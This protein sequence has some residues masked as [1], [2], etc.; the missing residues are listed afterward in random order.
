MASV[1]ADDSTDSAASVEW[2]EF[3]AANISYSATRMNR[4]HRT[5][6]IAMFIAAASHGTVFAIC[7][8]AG[9][10][11]RPPTVAVQGCTGTGEYA[12]ESG[13]GIASLSPLQ[14]PTI[15]DFK[16][17]AM[18]ELLNSHL[19]T[20]S[21]LDLKSTSK[22]PA[23]LLQFE[24]VVIGLPGSTS[25][26]TPVFSHHLPIALSTVGTAETTVGIAAKDD[27]SQSSTST[28]TGGGLVGAFGQPSPLSGNKPPKYPADARRAN[29]Q[30]TVWILIDVLENG[31]V[32]S[33]T[34][35][36]SCGHAMLDQIAL[37]AVKKWKYNPAIR[38]NL[39]IR[40]QGFQRIDFALD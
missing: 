30:G 19:P 13:N 35:D 18:P 36:E 33:A 7:W 27:S 5:A 25:N 37:E 17:P 12:D 21:L 9:L 20:S 40:S 34:I 29:M 6:I 24:D 26:A 31:T 28:G 14:M 11:S 1:E 22:S 15:P 2:V 16:E 39:P 3:D 32:A 23:D 38:D 8:Q 4:R 10:F